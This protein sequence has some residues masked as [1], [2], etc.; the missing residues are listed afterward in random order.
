L[1]LIGDGGDWGQE[2]INKK[3]ATER[4]CYRHGKV[5]N[6]SIWGVEKVREGE[7]VNTQFGNQARRRK[8]WVN[9]GK[10]LCRKNPKRGQYG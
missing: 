10:E 5:P 4:N 3:K 8:Q 2:E 6:R 9:S 7:G 1:W